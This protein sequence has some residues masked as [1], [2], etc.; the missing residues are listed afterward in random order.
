MVRELAA[1]LQ[2]PMI[3][4]NRWT[5][6][7]YLRLGAESSRELFCHFEPGEHAYWPDGLADNTHFREDGAR[8][9]AGYVAGQLAHAGFGSNERTTSSERTPAGIA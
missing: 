2:V 9:I 6:E 4:L 1:E 7:L 8:L 5:R 3:D